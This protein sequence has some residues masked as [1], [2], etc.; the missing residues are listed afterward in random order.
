MRQKSTLLHSSC[1]SVDLCCMI[2]VISIPR[3]LL[4]MLPVLNK[5][6]YFTRELV[7]ASVSRRCTVA[8]VWNVEVATTA[9]GLRVME[10]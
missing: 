9:E 6:S 1:V 2:C 4:L 5:H 10:R 7:A 3:V 8:R